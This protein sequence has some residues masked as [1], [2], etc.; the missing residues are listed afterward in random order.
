M[1]RVSACSSSPLYSLLL[2]SALVFASHFLA[3]EA[4]KQPPVVKGLSFSFFSK[5]CPNLE[6]IV[7]NHLKKVFQQDNG[8]APG[9]LRIFFHDCFVQGCDGSLLLDG[10]PGERDQVAN[11][12]IR[13]EALKTI[14]DLR[15][16]VHNECGRI[17]SCAD[18]TVLAARDAVFLSGGPDFAVP[19][20]RRDGLTFNN[21]GTKKLP[22]PFSNTSETI[23]R[24][25]EKNFDVTDVVA[26][27]GAHT[28]G[29][30]HC[31]TF[32]NRLSPLDPTMDKTLAK[33]LKSTCPDQNSAN[34]A[35]LDIRTP[36]LFDNKYYIDL[37]SKQ[38]VFTS[39][40]DL[41]NDQRTKGLVNSFAIDQNLFFQKFVNAV[42][43]L[44]QL[45]VLT[46]NQGEIRA[47]C[48]VINKKQ[49]ILTSVVEEVVELTI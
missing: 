45:D 18:I 42:I 21:D 39:D 34:T 20:G 4:Q 40:Q 14:D 10:K 23:K 46:G 8:Q 37:Q 32:F 31:G 26:F 47:K 1:A 48:N 3:S 28:F 41:L 5:N 12:G 27:S 33:N 35:N 11:G 24:F 16:L 29:R 9:L 19:L 2:I 38:G 36:T 13:T 25:A 43:K 30:A 22:S 6:T 15:G 49:S 44:S 7:R 17:V